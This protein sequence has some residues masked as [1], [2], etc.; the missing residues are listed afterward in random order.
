MAVIWSTSRTDSERHRVA[1]GMGRA[2]IGHVL[3]LFLLLVT[4]RL[5]LL[6]WGKGVRQCFA[7]DNTTGGSDLP[8]K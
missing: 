7:V 8:L 2:A 6:A 3:L 1:D 4:P 5:I